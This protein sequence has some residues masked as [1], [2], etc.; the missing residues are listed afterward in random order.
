M[1]ILRFR[2]AI[3]A[4][5][6]NSFGTSPRHPVRVK[7]FDSLQMPENSAWRAITCADSVDADLAKLKS[8]AGWR[9]EVLGALVSFLAGGQG[10]YL[11]F[12]CRT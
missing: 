7:N 11:F 8:E 10:K 1:G 4:S 5:W 9:I 12:P 6:A 2:P 3:S